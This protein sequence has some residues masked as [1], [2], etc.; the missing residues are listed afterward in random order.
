MIIDTNCKVCG[1]A[2]FSIWGERD[3]LTLYQCDNCE[4]VFFFPYPT[5]KELD[6]YYNNKYHERRG[7][8]GD[9]ED[10]QLRRH[11]YLMDIEDIEKRLGTEGDFL[12]VGCAEGVFL[13]MLDKNW[14]KTGIDVSVEAVERANQLENVSAY[15]GN[16]DQMQDGF[17]DV[18]HLRGVFEH[19]LEPNIF[20]L[21]SIAKL[22]P[23]GYLVLSNTPNIGG[24]V[25]RLF[26]GRYKLVIPNEHVNYFSIKTIN[27]L[28]SSVGY[29]I[30]AVCY[31]Y[32][33]SP[34]CSFVKDLLRIP[35][36]YMTGQLSP[37]F[38]GNIFTIYLQKQ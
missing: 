22:K 28:A 36:N 27:I 15:V 10:G 18:V 38:W 16:I 31:P 2:G 9:G 3:G 21:S 23:N 32:W 19:F 25:P 37:P 17:F 1:Q 7:Y 12:D 8:G 11:M 20:F 13:S 35:V 24:V 26:R 33:G 6:A 34:Y 4:L 30:K 5:Q 14:S 29:T